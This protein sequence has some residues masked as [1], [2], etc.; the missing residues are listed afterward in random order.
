MPGN[1][2][3]TFPFN[4]RSTAFA[5]DYLACQLR[6]CL[7]GWQ[8][9]LVNTGTGTY[10][11][12]ALWGCVGAWYAGEWRSAEAVG[13]V[14]RVRAEL[15]RADL[16]DAGVPAL[17]ARV[18]PRAGVRAGQLSA[19]RAARIGYLGP[20]P[21]RRFRGWLVVARSG[22]WKYD[23]EIVVEM[24]HGMRARPEGNGRR[25]AAKSMRIGNVRLSGERD[26]D[27]RVASRR[28]T[29]TRGGAGRRRSRRPSSPRGRPR[30]P[31]GGSS[32]PRTG[33]WPRR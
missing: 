16:A 10:R 9:W 30:P 31:A 11:P 3:G 28:P 15:A 25:R 17:P 26:V 5:A 2:N 32:A 7:E 6:G 13:Y 4:R 29:R 19:G 8:T 1:Q 20:C 14:E 24:H 21:T 33:R 18:R 22:R 27:R 23:R 12:G